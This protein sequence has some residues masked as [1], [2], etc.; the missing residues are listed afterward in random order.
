[1]KIK[2]A[3]DWLR[4]TAHLTNVEIPRDAGTKHRSALCGYPVFDQYTFETHIG[5]KL[6]AKDLAETHPCTGCHNVREL[7]ETPAARW[8]S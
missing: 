6:N 7:L 1:V 5:R 2:P 4:T 3:F 8:A